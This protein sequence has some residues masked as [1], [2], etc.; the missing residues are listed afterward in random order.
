MD[1]LY[2][3]LEGDYAFGLLV[4]GDD[5]FLGMNSPAVILGKYPFCYLDLLPKAD[6]V[7]FN[8]FG[9]FALYFL[10]FH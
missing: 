4:K 5:F 8:I 6:A 1:V 2:A 3:G 9:E 7:F 10:L